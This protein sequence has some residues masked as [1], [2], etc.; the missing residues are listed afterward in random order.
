KPSGSAPFPARSDRLMR[1]AF[2]ATSSGGSSG[3][4]WTPSMTPSVVTTRSCPGGTATTAASSPRPSAPGCVASGLKCFAL[5]RSSAAPDCD[6][7]VDLRAAIARK[8]RLFGPPASAVGGHEFAGA[9][10]ARERVEHRID[11]AGLLAIDKRVG[12][13]DI[14]RYDDAGRNV[15]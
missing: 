14:F 7:W 15:R 1:S 8:D 12:D 4:K 2:F 3:K 13:A 5:G 10:A 6:R 9:E 11:H